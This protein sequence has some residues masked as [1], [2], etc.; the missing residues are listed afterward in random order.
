MKAWGLTMI[1]VALLAEPAV[2]PICTASAQAGVDVAGAARANRAR[3][4]SP[5]NQSEWYSLTHASLHVQDDDGE[6]TTVYEMA[7]NH[8][9]RITINGLAKGKRETSQIMLINGQRQWMV[10]KNVPLE[11]G[12]EIDALDV[13]VLELKVALELLRRAV[14]DGP[15]HVDKKMNVN[16]HEANRPVSVNTT[17]AS[18]GIEA[19][20]TLE[21]TIEPNSAGELSFDLTVKHDEAMHFHGTWQEQATPPTFGDDMPLEGWQILSI[22]PFSRTDESGTTFDYGAQASGKRPRT[23]GELRKLGPS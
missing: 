19:P 10:T 9:M 6:T 5:N 11:R 18:G 20:W 2:R 22:G 3:A 8:D 7:E 23:L 15:R 1:A 21:G 17:S 12:S 13:P 14:P 4:A 16:V